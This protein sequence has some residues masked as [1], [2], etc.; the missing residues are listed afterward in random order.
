MVIADVDFSDPHDRSR[1][2]VVDF[3]GTVNYSLKARSPADAKKWVY[4]LKESKTWMLGEL[5]N[6]NL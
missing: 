3:K 2:D 5:L 4:A 6:F 1:F